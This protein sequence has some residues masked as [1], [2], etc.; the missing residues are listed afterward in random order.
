M[1]LANAERM[2]MVDPTDVALWNR[3]RL[4][5]CEQDFHQGGG[6]PRC[7]VIFRGSAECL[8]LAGNSCPP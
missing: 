2:P 7:V 4:F 6:I 8:V 1:V 5:E 3:M